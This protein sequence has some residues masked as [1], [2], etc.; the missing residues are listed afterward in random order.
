MGRRCDPLPGDH[1][2]ARAHSRIP[3]ALALERLLA[4][5]RRED[6][7]AGTAPGP[8]HPENRLG[9]DGDRAAHG[10]D[11]FAERLSSDQTDRERQYDDAVQSSLSEWARGES[12]ASQTGVAGGIG[13][14]MGPVVIGGGAAHSNA[15]SSS[16]QQ[17]G[18]S[19]SASEEQNLRDSIRRFGDIA[20]TP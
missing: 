13:F 10:D 20:E 11:V 9:A 2:R 4:R 3:S 18:R 5:D 16:S 1:G 12:S 8:P 15:S 6:A 17:G 7:D 19:G 14:A